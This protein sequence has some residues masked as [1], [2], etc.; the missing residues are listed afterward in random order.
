MENNISKYH[1][2]VEPF[3]EDFRGSLSW[4]KLSDVIRAVQ[5]HELRPADVHPYHD[6][7]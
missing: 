3:S 5:L 7:P 2:T 6:I 1:F 4:G